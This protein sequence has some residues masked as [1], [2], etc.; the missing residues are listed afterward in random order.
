[1]AGVAL[2]DY[3][4]DGWLD[5]YAVNGATCQPR[6]DG[7]GDWNRLFRNHGD[8]TF[9]DVTEPAGVAGRGLRPGRGRRRL[10]Q[11]RRRRHL[12]GRPAPEHA[13]PQQRRRHVQGRRRRPRAWPCRDPST[14]RSGRWPPPSSITTATAGWTCSSP[15]TASGTRPA[16]RGAA[17]RLAR[18]LP[19]APV[20]RA[21]PTRCSATTATARSAT[22]R[23]PPGSAP[24]S[25]REWASVSPTSTTTAGR[26]SSWRTTRCRPS[27]S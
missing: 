14:A 27:C 21:C 8:G 22:S 24:T 5:I 13:L 3:D 16:S 20:S 19:P 7:P 2:L 11:R 26:T 23:S 1:M 6:E 25:A 17:T 15:T 12:R 18:L 10:R 9:K 4:G